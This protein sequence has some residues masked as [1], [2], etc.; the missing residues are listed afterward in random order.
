MKTP[1]E[2]I[3]Q[4]GNPTGTCRHPHLYLCDIKQIQEDATNSTIRHIRSELSTLLQGQ[5]ESD[6]IEDI[7]DYLDSLANQN[8]LS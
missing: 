3:K 2:W 1:E 5:L 7:T 8:R 6:M 4:L